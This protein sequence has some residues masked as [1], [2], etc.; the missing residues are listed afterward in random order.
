LPKILRIV[1]IPVSILF[2]SFSYPAVR[3]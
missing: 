1:F 3:G 2:T